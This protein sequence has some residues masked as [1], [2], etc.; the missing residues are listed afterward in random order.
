MGLALINESTR[1]LIFNLAIEF[2]GLFLCIFGILNLRLNTILSGR[3]RRYFT[4]FL[5]LLF[6]FTL[7]NIMGQLLRGIPGPFA[8]ALLY[9]FNFMEFALSC[10]VFYVASMFLLEE[11]SDH[12][13]PGGN[14]TLFSRLFTTLLVLH[15]LLLTIS[16]FTGLIYTID[17]NNVYQRSS[18][19]FLIY[20]MVLIMALLDVILLI[21]N[22][23]YLSAKELTAF[24]MMLL[25]P[26]AAMI[27]QILVYGIYIIIIATII[28]ALIMISYIISDIRDS[29][30]GQARELDKLRAD[31]LQFQMQ[32]HFVYNTL[33]T[34][35]LL[36]SKDP[37]KAQSVIKQFIT[38]LKG[39]I[40]A[41]S[42]TSLIPFSEELEH[43]KSYV[44]IIKSRYKDAFSVVI[45]APDLQF[46]IPPLTIQPLV[47]NAIKHG[48][49]KSDKE[50][51]TILISARET[52]DAFEISVADDGP[53]INSDALHASDAA[54]REGEGTHIGL[55]NINE[56]LRIN[57]GGQLFLS[58]DPGVGTTATVHVPK[59]YT[60]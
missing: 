20:L 12:R 59:N 40:T 14:K 16:Q 33:N 35:Y 24:W 29:M 50:H 32:P 48:V 4:L 55:R 1:I 22:T 58:S 39:N 36:C 28:A 7:S 41:M 10:T 3:A 17:E 21:R 8:R 9:A 2:A 38:Y 23:S 54:K 6:A 51:N 31:I 37:D 46:F 19:Y 13:G 60:A 47:E 44:D 26:V 57:C 15:V 53:G 5:A 30:A 52:E 11:I 56:R 27:I 49:L 18:L 42:Q 45:E 25:L 34:A 43:V